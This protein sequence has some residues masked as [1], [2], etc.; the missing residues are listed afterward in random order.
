MD[1]SRPMRD[2]SSRSN[3]STASVG[4]LGSRGEN[5]FIS[6]WFGA[7][8]FAAATPWFCPLAPPSVAQIT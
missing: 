1:R 5:Q 8:A 4:L 7:G 3:S 2:Y 6:R